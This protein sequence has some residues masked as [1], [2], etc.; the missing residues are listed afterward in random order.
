MLRFKVHPEL[1][2]LPRPYGE[3]LLHIVLH[4]NHQ[5][6]IFTNRQRGTQILWTM[7]ENERLR[8]TRIVR[9]GWREESDGTRTGVRYYSDFNWATPKEYARYKAGQNY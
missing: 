8:P 1:F 3:D 9:R 4:A 5:H 7:D 6:R 2:K